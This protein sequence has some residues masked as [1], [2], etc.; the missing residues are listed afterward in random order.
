MGAMDPILPEYD[1]DTW[2]NAS[3]SERTKMACQDWV[4]RGFGNPFGVYFFYPIKL[5]LFWYLP[6]AWFCTF[7]PGVSS[8]WH[9]SEWWMQP[10]AFQKAL[11]WCIAF[12]IFGLGCASGPLSGHYNPP[13][14]GAPYFFRVGTLKA[15]LFRKAPLIGGHKRTPLDVLLYV[16]L[17]GV[18]V[19]A[20]VSPTIDP[21][22]HVVPAV[23][24]LF[25]FGVLDKTIFLAAR[26]E[27][28]LTAAV[29]L[30]F[31]TEWLAGTKWV[32]CAVWF[33]AGISK[34]THHFPPVL[35]TMQSTSPLTHFTPSIRKA[36]FASYPDDLNP[37]RLAVALAHLGAANELAIPLLLM[38]SPNAQVTMVGIGLMLWLHAFVT[39]SVPLGVPI[40]WN[41]MMV[42][43][44]I[45]LF[46]GHPEAS[47]FALRDPILI[48][49][50]AVWIG[51]IPLLG[52][53]A[54]R[55][56][57][58]LLSMRYYAGNWAYSVWLFEGDVVT[59]LDEKLKKPALTTRAQLA[60]MNVY[61]ADTITLMLSKLPVFR[62]MHYQGRMLHT[63]IPQAVG[64]L[65]RVDDY[66][67]YDG[68]AVATLAL[69][70]AFG[71]GHMHQQ[72]LLDAI[73][74]E[75]GFEAGQLRCV[76]VESQPL[77]K[78]SCAWRIV[79][80]KTG[81]IARGEMKV[82]EMLRRPAWPAASTSC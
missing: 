5:F 4:V 11:L 1:V 72:E 67:F 75:C 36:M 33:W 50:L 7:S 40:E 6:L 20:L 2:T 47:P 69:G 55:F 62:L 59:R 79:D 31:P 49:Y 39:F 14:G 48:A 51:L 18:I 60:A 82:E 53:L 65:E 61:D 43:G 77:L 76:F 80:A 3:W 63:L 52:N 23:A 45:F 15:P 27:H 16:A 28:Y 25:T 8:M 57:S 56:V 81:E 73:Q 30:L 34:L 35:A 17:L 78:Q 44:G 26:A 70:W 9:P 24:L 74:A 64:G 13:I 37:S 41:V 42:Y 12:E 46:L 29:C 32:W 22:K 19:W 68:E 21:R 54:P 58:F 71:D 66:E 10:I 38:F